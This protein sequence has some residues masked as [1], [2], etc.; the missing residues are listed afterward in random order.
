ME[1]ITIYKNKGELFKCHFNIEGASPKDTLVRLCLEFDNNVNFFFRGDLKENG[2]CII[3][4][5][6]LKNIEQETCKAIVE[7]VADEIYFKV[8]EADV[9]LRNS[10]E[11]TMQKPIPVKNQVKASIELEQI[12]QERL[13]PVYK[14]NSETTVEPKNPYTIKNKIDLNVGNTYKKFQDFLGKK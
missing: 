3:E 13:K 1:K 5:P 6:K 10:V 4:I 12:S 7:V 8:Y 9:D 2:D 14:E 11:V